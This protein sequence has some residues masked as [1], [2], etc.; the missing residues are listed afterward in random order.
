MTNKEGRLSRWSQLKSKGGASTEENQRAEDAA[1][2]R[3]KQKPVAGDPQ[4][5][6]V[7][8]FAITEGFPSN[9]YRRPA[10][11]MMT[12]LAGVEETDTEFEAAPEQALAMLNGEV[13]HDP[14]QP[15][16]SDTASDP[17]ED[18]EERELTP[19]EVEVVAALPPIETL[20][21]ESDFAP[22]MSGKV[23]EFIRRKALRVLWKTH[24]IITHLD[25]MNDY[26]DDFNVVHTLIDAATQSS[27]KVGRGQESA[28][29]PEES[30]ETDIPEQTAE[31]V[32]ADEDASP[33]A[34][35]NRELGAAT[36]EDK[37]EPEV[38]ETKALTDPEKDKEGDG[39]ER[40]EDTARSS[41][42]VRDVRKPGA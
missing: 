8:E 2:A 1:R 25:G 20:T 32:Y 29:E 35:A 40:S 18:E 30:A 26:D 9:R 21:D 4:A 19:E 17:V 42:P 16:P 33:S 27:Y 38:A 5:A 28:L 6:V 13:A 31:D 11:P 24:P 7:D 36:E 15:P 3:R 10:A 14:D 41:V 12:P 39:V 22:F 34:R 23:P 37:D